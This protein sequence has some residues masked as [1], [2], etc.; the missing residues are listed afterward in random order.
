MKICPFISHMLGDE[1]AD[2]L[3]SHNNP[4]RNGTSNSADNGETN[5]KSV[6]ILGYDGDTGDVQTATLTETESDIPQALKLSCL[7][8]SCRFYTT[9][10][11]SCRFD[12]IFELGQEHR[13]LARELKHSSAS[14][15]T[16]ITKELEKFWTFQTKSISEMIA[17]LGDA[18]KN[19]TERL[20]NLQTEINKSI[21]SMRGE[22]ENDSFLQLKDEI[23]K[24]QSVIQDREEAVD[25]L[26]TTIS[27]M[28]TN[29]DDGLSKLKDKIDHFSG[30]LDELKLAR[31]EF[32]SWRGD[33]ELQIKDLVDQRA[34]WDRHFT[35]LKEKQDELM[36]FAEKAAK[37]NDSKDE[38]SKKKE[39]KKLN[40]LGVTSFHNGAFEMAKEQFQRAIE[41]DESSAEAY[42]NLGLV[43]TELGQE[44]NASEAFKKAIELNPGLSSV[45]TNLGYIFFK[46]GSYERAIEMYNEALGRN[47]NST[48]AYTN[49]GNAYY[50][51]DKIEEARE[52][53]NKAIDI[54]PSN[55]K[56]KR[57]LKRLS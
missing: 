47:S 8:E 46:Q 7:K 43:Y 56:A 9:T 32:S 33:I 6:L 17:S 53:W 49:L 41:L 42:N 37:R 23:N 13:E 15:N 55:D 40:N 48:A 35:S 14:D 38:I 24:F 31:E 54:D 10:S 30:R 36:Q 18:E 11:G 52:A 50:K 12:E 25:N 3:I 1:S 57:L 27:E 20:D 19:Q 22:D 4:T 26:S 28:V 39:A 34:D 29:I 2:V 21:E 44:D 45:Y 5:D 16:H 51:L